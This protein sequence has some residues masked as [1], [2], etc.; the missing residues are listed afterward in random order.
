[1]ISEQQRPMT[2]TKPSRI[3]IPKKRGRKGDKIINAFRN[4]PSTPT[5][6]E[7]FADIHG[8]SIGVL[9]QIKR[10]DK[11]GLPGTVKVRKNTSGILMIWR[12]DT[13]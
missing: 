3:R 10:F 13:P 9:R 2:A 4:I 7:S 5:D 11:T 1:M 12:D 8:I 6:A